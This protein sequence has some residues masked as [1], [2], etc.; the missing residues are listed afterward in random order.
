MAIPSLNLPK[1][2]LND[3]QLSIGTQT[4]VDFVCRLCETT[5]DSTCNSKEL[6]KCTQTDGDFKCR[7]CGSEV[8]AL[9]STA[10]KNMTHN[11]W[12][13]THENFFT[14]A[15]RKRKLHK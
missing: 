8:A 10:N 11:Q 13:Q 2:T 6:T 14:S 1:R 3:N 15:K 4:D 7:I 9:A 12:V 5:K